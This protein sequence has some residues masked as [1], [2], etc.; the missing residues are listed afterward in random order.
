ML[1]TGTAS[2]N[3]VTQTFSGAKKKQSR[4]ATPT[5]ARKDTNPFFFCCCLN[6]FS[7]P[8]SPAASIPCKQRCR[9]QVLRVPRG[10]PGLMASSWASWASAAAHSPRRLRK[11]IECLTGRGCCLEN[12]LP[13]FKTLLL[14]N[15]RVKIPRVKLKTESVFSLLHSELMGCPCEGGRKIEVPSSPWLVTRGKYK[16]FQPLL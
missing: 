2:V 4:E 14:K 16:L 11:S 12:S 3:K 13:L 10:E 6:R 1:G 7:S 9:G 8:G 15:V 5:T